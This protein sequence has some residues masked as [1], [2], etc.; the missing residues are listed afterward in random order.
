MDRIVPEPE[1]NWTMTSTW[2]FSR[3]VS[4]LL[5]V[6]GV[7]LAPGVQAFTDLENPSDLD[8][9]LSD[10][11]S[12]KLDEAVETALA[13]GVESTYLAGLLRGSHD[14]GLSA[15][16]L[17]G[18]V[19]RTER[20]A[21]G[22]LPVAPVVSRYLQGLAK[23][24]PAPRIDIVIDDLE[25]R[26]DESAWRIDSVCEVGTDPASQRARLLSIDH[27]AYALGLGVSSDELSHSIAL[28][29]E[30][31]GTIK[32][33]QAPVLTLGI[34][35]SAGIAP[36]KSLEVVDTAWMHGYR[37]S[38]LERLGKSVGR[39]GRDGQAPSPEV[40]NEVIEMIGKEAS[41]DR[42]FQGLDELA[43][44][45]EYRVS[46]SYPGNDP[47]RNMIPPPKPEGPGDTPSK[48]RD[49]QTRKRPS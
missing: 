43:G 29:W 17:V 27:G 24:V 42:V 7:L 36:G 14:R 45:E 33:V 49:R 25:S 22:N 21:K 1:E 34:L 39:L 12:A 4:A 5:V 48:D 19:N 26:L 13:A 9:M 2:R 28:A 47:A 3:S 20:L 18:W 30:E 46:G 11:D 37:G 35:V 8:R 6:L 41:K 38:N 16:V 31:M 32:A 40:V 10:Y 15:D 23:G 44:R